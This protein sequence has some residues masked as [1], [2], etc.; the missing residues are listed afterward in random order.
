MANIRIILLSGGSGTRLWPLSNEVRSKQFLKLLKGAT[1]EPES[2]CQR[3]M[4]QLLKSGISAD[5]TVATGAV[6]VDSILKQMG[7]GVN[8]VAEPE[9]R[10][11]FPAIALACSY[12]LLEKNASPNDIVIVMPIDPYTE[13]SYFETIK[14][15]ADAVACDAANIVLMGIVPN[16]PSS[17][18]GYIIPKENPRCNAPTAVSHFTEKPEQEVA[19]KLIAQGAMWNGG[20]F[21]FKMKFIKE[22][23][24]R[25]TT[26]SSF[27]EIKANYAEFPKKSFDFEILEKEPSIAVIPYKGT[28]KDLGTWDTLAEEMSIQSLGNV[29][30]DESKNTNIVN[31]LD[32]PI[33]CLGIDNAIVAASFD[34]IFVGSKNKSAELKKYVNGFKSRPMYEERRWGEYKVLEYTQYPD[35]KKSLTK[36]LKFNDG[37]FISY[38]RHKFRDEI[39]TFVAGEGILIHNNNRI[40]VKSGDLVRI[41]AGELH[42]IKSIKGLQIIEIQIGVELTETDIE[43]FPFEW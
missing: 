18:F 30:A 14:R 40:R 36:I 22:V 42:A 37:A 1:G 20:V 41:K 5:I 27:D 43:R 10:D 15:M 19:K 33:V 29:I 38:Q 3:I 31:E 25:Y 23:I 12:L 6:Q 26:R 2:M 4:R 24:S 7:E 11:T 35:G 17:K 16:E 28:W 39:W 13:D 9:R 34:G 32:I 21:A 8:I